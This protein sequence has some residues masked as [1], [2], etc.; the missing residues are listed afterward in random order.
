[1]TSAA[2][3]D[4]ADLWGTDR[5]RQNAAYQSFMDASTV[6][7]PWAHDVWADVVANLAHADNHNRAI[8]AQ[9][10]CNLA[11]RDTTDRVLGDL[12]AL[13]EVTRDA[14]FVTA[15]HA[16]KSLWRIG[17]AGDVQRRAVLAV[18]D[19]RYREAEA[20]KNGTLI[21]HDVVESLRSLHDAVADPE[22][23]T[24]ARELIALETDLKYRK[25]YAK[26]W[27]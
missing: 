1:M 11:S 4:F 27:R 21:R 9:L 12:D 13:V 15:R 24:T 20:E 3:A 5:D 25:K 6:P 26:H 10:L 18:L 22:V 19:A 14:R 7:V 2:P 16:L 17:L 8:A 23:E